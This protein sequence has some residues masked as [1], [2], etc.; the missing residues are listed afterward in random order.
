MYDV[1]SENKTH[2][3]IWSNERKYELFLKIKVSTSSNY[4]C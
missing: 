4:D 2:F 1:K 3:T